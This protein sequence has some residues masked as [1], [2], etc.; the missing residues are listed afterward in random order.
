MGLAL[1]AII[2]AWRFF[3]LGPVRGNHL[4]WIKLHEFAAEQDLTVLAHNLQAVQLPHRFT[5]E[6]DRQILWV[7]DQ[8]VAQQALALIE[9]YRREPAKRVNAPQPVQATKLAIPGLRTI[10]ITYTLLLLSIVG[11][12]FGL[13]PAAW[14]QPLLFFPIPL[15]GAVWPA[16]WHYW[17]ATGEWWRLITPAFLHWSAV[18]I[19]FNAL[20]L[21]DFGGRLERQLPWY[22]YLGLFLFTAL[23]SN[24]GQFTF[25][26]QVGF[27][28][29]SGA[30]FGYFGCIFAISW[31][32]P[33]SNLRLPK[34]FVVFSLA[35]IVA[36]VLGLLDSIIGPMANGAHLTGL[37]AGFIYGMGV[38]LLLKKR[39]EQSAGDTP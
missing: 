12:L 28:G 18:H 2:L 31:L 35:M 10:P 14:R 13:A 26:P 34:V 25:V 24:F 32:V 9:I 7:P 33:R 3:I 27:G 11:Y 19:I 17:V 16:V 8:Y 15:D 6:L 36:G 1:A 23:V 30:L 29:I 22:V 5:D 37:A 38:G 4:S 20:A 39:L 21:V